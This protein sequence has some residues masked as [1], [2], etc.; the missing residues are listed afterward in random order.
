MPPK[1]PPPPGREL[2]RGPLEGIRVV[3]FGLAVAGPWSSQLL[4]DLGAEV[5]VMDVAAIDYPCAQS[6]KVDLRD[7]ASVDAAIDQVAAPIHAIFSCAGVA[8]GPDLM[9]INFI[10][11]RH[12]IDRLIADGTLGR[13]SAIAI[14]ALSDKFHLGLVAY[15]AQWQ[16]DAHARGQQQRAG[17]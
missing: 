2:T 17:D 16:H 6:L 15:L 11:Q 3:D 8:D 7:R 10:A 4:A 14:D 13:G 9:A 5:V 1:D 12:L